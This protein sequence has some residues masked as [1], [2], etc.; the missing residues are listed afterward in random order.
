MKYA[1]CSETTVGYHKHGHGAFDNLSRDCRE[2]TFSSQH[3]NIDTSRFSAS[4]LANPAISHSQP[5]P[6]IVTVGTNPSPALSTPTADTAAAPAAAPASTAASAPLAQ[7][8]AAS[9]LVTVPAPTAT[10]NPAVP[11]AFDAEVAYTENRADGGFLW[12]V[13]YELGFDGGAFTVRTRIHLTGDNPGA[14]AQTWEQGIESIWNNKYCLS[15]GTRDYAINFDVQFVGA[16]D[17]H[18]DVAVTAGYGRDDMLDW[19]TQSSWGPDYQDD[20]AAHEYGHM[21]GCFDEYAGGATYRN[22]AEGGTIMSDLTDTLRP[23]Y[24]NSIDYYADYFTGENLSI[25]AAPQDEFQSGSPNPDTMYGGAGN[26][27]L[28]GLAGGDWLAGGTG[29]DTLYG[30]D[31]NDTLRGQDGDD[32]LYGGAGKDVMM[33]DAGNDTLVPDAGYDTLYGGAGADVFVFRVGDVRDMIMDFKASEGDRIQLPTGAR[34]YAASN[35]AGSTV[36]T[37]GGRDQ[38]LL[39]GIASSQVNAGWFSYG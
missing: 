17:E 29:N 23:N 10:T 21:I 9:P 3:L 12:D 31:G 18:Y 32:W 24:M 8:P 4:R 28:N 30:G 5:V 34:W 26:D 37:M 20:L 33:G 27:V 2:K 6:A 19:S 36:V 38:V 1:T 13:K 11:A 25:V 35:G 22:F 16:G 39:S 15:D 7:P 14:L